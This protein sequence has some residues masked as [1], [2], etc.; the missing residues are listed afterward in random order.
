MYFDFC[1]F[2]F[3]NIGGLGLSV[4][5]SCLGCEELTYACTGIYLA[6]EGSSLGVGVKISKKYQFHILSKI[7]QQIPVIMVGNKDQQKKYLGRL[8]DESLLAVSIQVCLTSRFKFE[9]L[10]INKM[11]ARHTP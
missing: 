4:F 7:F 5:D 3:T 8:L 9:I 11:S 1:N 6:F 2:F 10:I